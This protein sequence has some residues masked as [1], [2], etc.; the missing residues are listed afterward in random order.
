MG[1]PTK[2]KERALMLLESGDSMSK[3][4]EMFKISVDSLSR[5][6]RRKKETGTPASIKPSGAKPKISIQEIK[7]YIQE[8]PEAYDREIAE[9][10]GVAQASARRARLRAKITNKKNSKIHRKRRKQEASISAKARSEAKR[11]FGIY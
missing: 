9:H 6:K 4:A 7:E 3:V 1:Y 11:R 2:F 5:W 8:H 10:F